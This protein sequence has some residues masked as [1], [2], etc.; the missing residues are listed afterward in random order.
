MQLYRIDPDDV[1]TA[2][3]EEGADWAQAGSSTRREIVAE[4]F[5]DK[6]RH[7]L[8]VV[9]TQEDEAVVVITAY[10]LRKERAR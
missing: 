2:I 8:K 9:Y 1:V 10:P 5:R 4:V 7:P 6:Y 3:M